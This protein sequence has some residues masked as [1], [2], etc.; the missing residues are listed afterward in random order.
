[1][2]LDLNGPPANPSSIHAFGRRAKGLL[3]KARQRVANFFG[4][5]P[6]EIVFTSGGT[7]G[8][9]SVLRGLKGHIITTNIEHSAVDQTLK[10]LT[11]EI[12]YLPVG[13][14]GAPLPEQI[15]E[16]ILPSTSAIVLSASNNETGVKIDLPAIA[17]IAYTRGVFLIVDAV[18]YIGKEPFILYP[19]IGA[20][21]LSAHKF[22]G[23][24]GIGA[25]YLNGK[26]KLP[27]LITGGPQE[28]HHRAGT[29]NLA[30]ILGLA[31][32]LDLMTLEIPETLLHLR[33]RL[34]EGLK[35]QI[36]D[37]AINGQALRISNTSNIAFSGIDGEMLLTQLDMAGI[38]VSHG[39][40]CS[41]G[42]IEPS[43][44]LINMGIDRKTARSSIRFSLSRMNTKEEI[45]RAIEKIA[46]TVK[47]LRQI[48][49]PVL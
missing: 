7:E 37:I 5:K 19:G 12:T 39:S 2:L 8:I 25:L 20:V 47:K 28:N 34:E 9:N 41:S 38:A 42:S 11:Q 45:D 29:E 3:A 32:A 14:W 16:A 31:E 21:V 49:V 15:E 44:V 27:S 30:G 24:K 33:L 10:V 17:K 35:S 46:E 26:M 36:P 1:M 48:A 18:S 43:R 23:P 40:A 6:E 4:A 22:H 13:L